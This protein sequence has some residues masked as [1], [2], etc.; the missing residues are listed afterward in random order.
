MTFVGIDLL[1]VPRILSLI[2]RRGS[3]RLAKRILS[4]Q[5]YNSW[6]VEKD[7]FFLAKMFLILTKM[8][9]FV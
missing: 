2:A 3:E 4:C 7:T 8:I 5:E 6:S 9:D 1:H